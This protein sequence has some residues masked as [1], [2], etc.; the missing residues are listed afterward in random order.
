MNSAS[1]LHT[2]IQKG[3]CGDPLI[4]LSNEWLLA[5]AFSWQVTIESSHLL[6]EVIAVK[7]NFEGTLINVFDFK[8]YT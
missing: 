8:I 3:R 4:L 7:F 6:K 2:V 1:F 5:T